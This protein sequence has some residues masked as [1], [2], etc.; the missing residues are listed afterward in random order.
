[1]SESYTNDTQVAVLQVDLGEDEIVVTYQLS[2]DIRA[3]AMQQHQLAILRNEPYLEGIEDLVRAAE[4]LVKDVLEDWPHKKVLEPEP[5][6]DDD[7]DRGMG[8]G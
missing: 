7:D 5:D 1:M 3:G 8:F 6:D 2:T 4:S